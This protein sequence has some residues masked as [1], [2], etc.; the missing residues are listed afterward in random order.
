MVIPTQY[1]RQVDPPTGLL[2][3][4]SYKP[5]RTLGPTHTMVHLRTKEVN[6]QEAPSIAAKEEPTEAFLF[7]STF[8]KR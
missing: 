1:V 4:E 2:D 3:P 5:S 6:P 7:A 8:P